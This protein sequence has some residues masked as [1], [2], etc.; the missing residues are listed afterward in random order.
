M[1][2]FIQQNEH[3]PAYHAIAYQSSRVPTEDGRYLAVAWYWQTPDMVGS[4]DY[5]SWVLLD[6]AKSL[7]TCAA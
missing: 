3:K 7:C 5:F 1:L 2:W 6:V 4:V